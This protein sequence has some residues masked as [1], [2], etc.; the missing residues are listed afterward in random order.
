[1]YVYIEYLL[2]ENMIINFIIYMLQEYYKN[3][4]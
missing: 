2:L 4:I 3:K 1:M